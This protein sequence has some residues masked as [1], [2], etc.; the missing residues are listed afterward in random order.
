M[1][2]PFAALSIAHTL[3]HSPYLRM[4]M[5]VP[6]AMSRVPINAQAEVTVE[7]KERLKA[8]LRAHQH[9][10]ITPEIRRELFSAHSRGEAYTN[11]AGGV[12]AMTE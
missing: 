6:T 7:Q 9:A 11:F 3:H 12:D 5:C 4:C 8:V 10:Q 1:H 2:A